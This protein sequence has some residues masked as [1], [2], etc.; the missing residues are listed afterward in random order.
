[1][2]LRAVDNESRNDGYEYEMEV[3]SGDKVEWRG[4]ARISRDPFFLMDG[5]TGFLL[6]YEPRLSDDETL[7]WEQYNP[8]PRIV[9]RVD[10]FPLTGG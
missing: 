8:I 4:V 9:R 3:N 2:A 5:R 7:E 6:S 1:M 10:S